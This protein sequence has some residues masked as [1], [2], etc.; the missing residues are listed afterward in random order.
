MKG[1]QFRQRQS[2]TNKHTNEV[3]KLLLRCMGSLCTRPLT[4]TDNTTTIG[5]FFQTFDDK[6]NVEHPVSCFWLLG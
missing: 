4:G 3:F 5:I 1:S 6:F 2:S